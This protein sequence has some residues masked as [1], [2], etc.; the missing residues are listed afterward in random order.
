MVHRR[1][2]AQATHATSF[3][4][5]QSQI[6][7]SL[8]WLLDAA[9]FRPLMVLSVFGLLFGLLCT[10]SA[11]AH[12]APTLIGDASHAMDPFWTSIDTTFLDWRCWFLV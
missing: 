9:V 5:I 6:L 7:S 11:L 1:V 3:W 2:G 4:A 10:E 8:W 12:G